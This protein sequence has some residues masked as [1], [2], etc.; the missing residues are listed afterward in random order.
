MQTAK[1]MPETITPHTQKL[2]E[3]FTCFAVVWV[4]GANTQT[5]AEI[6]EDVATVNGVI[7]A[8]FSRKDPWI[9]LASYNPEITDPGEIM[10]RIQRPGVQTRIVGC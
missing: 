5:E 3:K 1:S 8:R 2:A 4:Q 6:L 10:A 9:L 7:T